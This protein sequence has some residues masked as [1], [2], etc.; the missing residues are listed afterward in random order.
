MV[1]LPLLNSSLTVFSVA[2]TDAGKGTS[3]VAQ[4][5]ENV[6]ENDTTTA[7]PQSKDDD[8]SFSEAN[9]NALLDS[10]DAMLS[11]MQELGEDCPWLTECLINERDKYMVLELELVSFSSVASSHTHLIWSVMRL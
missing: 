2:P 5:T 8:H 10:E 3:S 4:S 9:I 6:A 7:K 1:L 11:G